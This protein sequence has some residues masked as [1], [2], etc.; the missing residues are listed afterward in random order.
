MIGSQI[1]NETHFQYIH[2]GYDQTP[3]SGEP[4]ITV[5]GAFTD[6]GSGEGHVIYHHNHYELRND[7]SLALR[8]HLV[9]FGGR[10]R[11]LVEPYSSTADFNGTYTFKSLTAYRVTL[12]GLASGMTPAVIAAAGGGPSQFT[13]VSG[14]PLVNIRAVD[15][16]IYAEDNWRVGSNVTLSYGLRFETQ[17]YIRD[18]ADWA[19]RLGVA[20][21]IGQGKN[22]VPKTVLRVGFGMF[23]DRFANNLIL[24]AEQLNGTNQ[25]EYIVRAP[26][27]Y[28]SVPNPSSLLTQGAATT[29]YRIDTNLRAP[30]TI[31]SA[32]S[33]ERQ[34]TTSA[35]VSL[36]Y[37][38]SRGV[39]QLLTN[40]V[41]APLPGT[42]NPAV[43]SS[44]VRPNP[45][46]G[47]IYDYES[48]AIFK[49][50]EIIANVNVRAG[51]KLSLFGFY[52][53]NYANSDTGGPSSFP[54]NPYNIAQDYGRAA[55]AIRDRLLMGGS[56]ALPY[57][58]RLSPLVIL[59][60]GAPFNIIGIGDLN[61]ST[62]FN[63]R[64][65]FAT[66][67]TPAQDVLNTRY[68]ALNIAP[69]AGERLIPIN[70]GTGP[71]Q[72]STNLRVSKTISFGV[73]AN[74]HAAGEPNY[75][76]GNQSASSGQGL[77][78]RGLSNTASSGSTANSARRRFSFTFSV[79][80]RNI[81]NVVNLASPE[82]HL[83]SPLFDRS[84][85][86]A[87]GNFSFNGVNRRIDMQ[88]IFNF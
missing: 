71:R 85:S 79:S 56:M 51:A 74:E 16:G 30:Y 69:A 66:S 17:N 64:P 86:L 31:Q 38:N 45:G 43:P 65:A 68:G 13:L 2:E 12:Q 54:D 77:E 88:C 24:Q 11:A 73:R 21:G 76:A 6:G 70:Y 25:T 42:Y 19:P 15:A 37:L 59:Q 7:T 18:R 14:T 78:G 60:S 61:G 41:N 87:G 26:T 28:P 75:G 52:S 36:T 44:G 39:H 10:L 35:T 33:V 27:F 82:G 40:N 22:R 4:E 20:W 72:F 58:F 8:D 46:L 62:V 67:S 84:I 48:I 81:F 1:V 83:A 49:Q 9:K 80:G 47:N 29:V 34:L 57:G 32:A 55:F 23:Y 5:L 50:N 53:L 63:Q 3:V